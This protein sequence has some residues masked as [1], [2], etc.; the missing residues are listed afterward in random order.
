MKRILI[1]RDKKLESWVKD[2]TFLGGPG[3]GE[4]TIVTPKQCT[5]ISSTER[6]GARY[7]LYRQ[8][9]LQN[10]DGEVLLPV[11]PGS[12]EQTGNRGERGRR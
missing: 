1:L 11:G 2:S 3:K 9:T 8:D 12:M 7:L 4:P 6:T 5:C 10:S